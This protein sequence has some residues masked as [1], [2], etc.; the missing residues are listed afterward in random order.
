MVSLLLFF[1]FCF[2]STQIKGRWIGNIPLSDIFN[3]KMFCL[4]Q[5][6]WTLRLEHTILIGLATT[7]YTTP[8][9]HKPSLFPIIDNFSVPST[10]NL[11]MLLLLS[12]RHDSEGH[13]ISSIVGESGV[14]HVL[15]MLVWR[16]KTNYSIQYI[17]NIVVTATVEILRTVKSRW[18]KDDQFLKYSVCWLLCKTLSFILIL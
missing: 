1:K 8:Y 15:N 9:I 3:N 12:L 13:V 7:Q 14:N 2:H 18:L 5:S 4:L 6:V 16:C 17:W 11:G 10:W